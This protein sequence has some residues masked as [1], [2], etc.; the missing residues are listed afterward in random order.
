MFDWSDPYGDGEKGK[1][2]VYFE[3]RA[4]R[5]YWPIRCGAQEWILV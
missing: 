1:D 4:N 3:G 2:T 5:I